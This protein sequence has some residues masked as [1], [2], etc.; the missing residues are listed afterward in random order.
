MTL[1][2]TTLGCLLAFSLAPAAYANDFPR[3]D[4]ALPLTID[5]S[6]N[7]PVFDFDTDGCLPSAGI[8]RSGQQNGGLKPTGSI[9]GGCRASKS[10]ISR[11]HCTAT[12]AS[13]AGPTP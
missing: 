5:I 9:T 1:N 11:T 4:E 2:R 12:L 7:D 6:S 13:R 3:L 10:S 8:S